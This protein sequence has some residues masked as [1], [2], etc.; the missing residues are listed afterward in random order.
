MCVLAILA[1]VANKSGGGGGSDG[2]SL[3][4][5]T[6]AVAAGGDF[7][8]PM[9]SAK[10]RNVAFDNPVRSCWCTGWVLFLTL[11]LV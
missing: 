8:N 9:H 1:V 2:F 11:S 6:G 3:G 5:G 7:E 10:E 4:K